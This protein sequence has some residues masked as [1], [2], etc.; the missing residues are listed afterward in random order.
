M[1]RFEAYWTWDSRIIG[2]GDTAEQDR[3]LTAL[4]L[5]IP[6]KLS[7]YLP[8]E[9]MLDVMDDPRRTDRIRDDLGVREG[10]VPLFPS[11][12]IRLELKVT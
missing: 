6:T 12:Q 3:H 11:T 9:D 2:T 8:V 1:N 4:D 5:V 7:F 10:I